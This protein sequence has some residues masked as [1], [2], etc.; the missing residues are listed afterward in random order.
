MSFDNVMPDSCAQRD[1]PGPSGTCGQW[2]T[3]GIKGLAFTQVIFIRS[4]VLIEVSP[5]DF[6][7]SGGGQVGA[8]RAKVS[9]GAV[10]YVTARHARHPTDRLHISTRLERHRSPIQLKAITNM[11]VS[12]KDEDWDIR[13]KLSNR[14]VYEVKVCAFSSNCHMTC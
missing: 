4:S 9:F 8:A 7:I 12:A 3:D 1:Q 6:E 13:V 11:G 14:S 10:S 2:H 5:A